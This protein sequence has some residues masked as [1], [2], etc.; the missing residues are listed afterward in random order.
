MTMQRGVYSVNNTFKPVVN[1]RQSNVA[2]KI[3]GRV[4]KL[5]ALQTGRRL[6]AVFP[7]C[8]VDPGNTGEK[9]SVLHQWKYE[10]PG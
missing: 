3:T 9:S 4:L 1:E 5:F 6:L 7:K 2:A 10:R 8:L